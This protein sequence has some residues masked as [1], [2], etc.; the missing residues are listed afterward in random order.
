MH[1]YILLSIMLLPILLA[2]S[3]NNIEFTTQKVIVFKDGY[4]LVIK[5]G[6]AT[7][8]DQGEIISYSVPESA[9]LGSLWATAKEANIT[10]LNAE[11]REVVTTKNKE[12]TCTQH[13]EILQVNKGKKCKVVTH[14]KVSY[15]GTIH[16]VLSNKTRENL[17]RN[18][19]EVRDEIAEGATSTISGIS[20]A[21]FVLRTA[22]QD[23]LLGTSQ[24][25]SLFIPNMNVTMKRQIEIKERRKQLTF[26]FPEANKKHRITL[27]YFTP[28]MRWVPSYRISLQND[29]LAS[30]SL[31]AEIINENEDLVDV[32][33][34]IVVGVPNF[35]F[36]DMVS[37]LSLE[38]TLR[39][40]LRH[41]NRRRSDSLSNAIMSQQRFNA[42]APPQRAENN[43]NVN[44]PSELTTK[45]SQDLFV[46]K[47]PKLSIR[48]GGRAAV[49]I[50][51]A[52]V[53]YRDIYTWKAAI[54][55]NLHHAHFSKS[56]T[57]LEFSE[58]KIWHEIELVNNTQLPWTTGA[59]MIMQGEQP[60]AQEL[61]TY[62]S[63]GG[64]V[65]VRVTVAI[66]V[67]GTIEEKETKRQLREMKWD[68]YY[69]AKIANQAL[70]DVCN[71]KRK[72]INVEIIFNFGGKTTKVSDDG[73]VTLRGYDSRDWDNYRGSYA[74]N[75]SSTVKWTQTIQPGKN[76]KPTVDYFYYAR[77]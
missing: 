9:V 45:G 42:Y 68:G 55:H 74:V 52:K 4:C 33:M 29:N 65:R 12:F 38:N 64:K 27:M 6:S 70:L 40:V 57:Q 47:L 25:R 13:I 50:F 77:H 66:D 26:H 54:K 21:Y 8:N 48:K 11:W 73:K 46:Y 28:G 10:S 59:A 16:E 51:S 75:N 3:T 14:D 31:Q 15:E 18:M 53:K 36:R 76:F 56:S 72:E 71:N 67:Q 22:E 69:Y 62:T 34:D 32:P 39:N 7:T 19:W 60:L 37:P 63:S 43:G 35:R 2:N 30:V 1:K 23:V 20:G 49:H 5:E 44:L 61:L 17:P 24:I 58:N 41:S